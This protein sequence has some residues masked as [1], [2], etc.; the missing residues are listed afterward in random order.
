MINE[1]HNVFSRSFNILVSYPRI[2]RLFLALFALNAIVILGRNSELV[3][4]TGAL[5]L[6]VTI[7]SVLVQIYFIL[8]VYSIEG[9][10]GK[11][12]DIWMEARKYFWK[13]VL[14]SFLG[15]TISGLIALPLL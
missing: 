12:M 2:L 6:G 7:F 10:L 4:L 15:L 9:V 3:C 1:F 13:Y 5:S 14:Q 11:E 8:Y